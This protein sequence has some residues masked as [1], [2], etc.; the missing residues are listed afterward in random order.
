MKHANVLWLIT[1]ALDLDDY[2][3]EFALEISEIEMAVYS[4]IAA[5][6]AFKRP[7]NPDGRPDRLP[8]VASG[9]STL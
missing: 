9:C 7:G 3:M 5:D 2:F 6:V 8:S 1:P 4:R